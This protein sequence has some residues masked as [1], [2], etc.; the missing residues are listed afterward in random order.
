M[1]NGRTWSHFIAPIY[2]I[3]PLNPIHIHLRGL[4]VGPWELGSPSLLPN[5]I[6]LMC[7]VL[8]EMNYMVGQWPCFIF[9]FIF[10]FI[11]FFATKPPGYAMHDIRA[12]A[13][14]ARYLLY[15]KN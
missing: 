12:C 13:F 15:D 2:T 8:G 5:Y 9:I 1:V 4:T 11:F 3:M 14:P 10:Y 6:T 7:S